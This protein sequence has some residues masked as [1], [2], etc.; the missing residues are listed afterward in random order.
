MADFI[1]QVT[2]SDPR[3]KLCGYMWCNH[4]RNDSAYGRMGIPVAVISGHKIGPT[5]LLLGGTHGDEYI[6]QAALTQLFHSIDPEKI[7]GRIIICSAA[8]FPAAQAGIRL[9][10]LDDMNLNGVYPG[11]SKGSITEKI[12]ALVVERL[13]TQA[14]YVAD[15]HSGGRSLEYMPGA[16]LPL[17]GK[18]ETDVISYKLASAFGAGNIFIVPA[19][20]SKPRH[21]TGTAHSLNIPAVAFEIGGTEFIST[22]EMTMTTSGILNMLACVGMTS[23]ISEVKSSRSWVIRPEHYLIS[24]EEGIFV[25]R[26]KL[27]DRIRR[28]DVAGQIFNN[29]SLSVPPATLTYPADG[30][31]ACMRRIAKT[32]I[33]DCLLHLAATDPRLVEHLKKSQTK[34][35]GQPSVLY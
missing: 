21:A 23:P 28:G 20:N 7:S 9:S 14:N 24:T 2:F 35:L 12:A 18:A 31:V 1:D 27:G 30:V 34:T 25:P 10:P 3:G 22:K 15:I 26:N 32:T 6:G 33:G 13:M 17:S 4:P 19:S 11:N 29:L 16:F 5:F 8:N